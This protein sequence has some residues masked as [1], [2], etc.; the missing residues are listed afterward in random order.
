MSKL[1]ANNEVVLALWERTRMRVM[2]INQSIQDVLEGRLEPGRFNCL[3]FN[4]GGKLVTDYRELV[5]TPLNL[6]CDVFDCA[7][8]LWNKKFGPCTN[9]GSTWDRLYE[10]IVIR[11]DFELAGEIVENILGII[12]ST[13]KGLKGL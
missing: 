12:D 11:R 8:C 7:G 3:G 4:P 6:M 9:Y 2:D 10:S 13:I 5:G 1:M